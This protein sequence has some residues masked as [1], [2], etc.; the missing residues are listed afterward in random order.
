MWSILSITRLRSLGSK[1]YVHKYLFEYHK[2]F[3]ISPDFIGPLAQRR[4]QHV[5][6]VIRTSRKL[7]K[8]RVLLSFCEFEF[9]FDRGLLYHQRIS[10]QRLIFGL[11]NYS[12]YP[13]ESIITSKILTNMWTITTNIRYSIFNIQFP[14]FTNM[15][16]IFTA[17]IPYL[18]CSLSRV[19]VDSS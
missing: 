19:Q 12:M 14:M 6:E 1:Q 17:N 7:S 8:Q 11:T 15:Y 2:Y 4:T 18:I 3:Q 13:E 16:S 5:Q 9:H 10:N